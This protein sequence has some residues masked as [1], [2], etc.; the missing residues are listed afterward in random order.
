MERHEAR[1]DAEDRQQAFTRWVIWT[2]C[3]F[4]KSRRM[5]VKDFLSRR[6]RVNTSKRESLIDSLD[7]MAASNGLNNKAEEEIQQ[8]QIAAAP[9]AGLL[10]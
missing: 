6:R 8:R 4:G 1:L 7:N 10:N 9:V 5:T 2:R 3:G